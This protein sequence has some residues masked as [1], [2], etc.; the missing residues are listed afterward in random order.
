MR[1]V[2]QHGGNVGRPQDGISSTVAGNICSNGRGRHHSCGTGAGRVEREDVQRHLVG[3]LR[4]CTVEH[5]DLVREDI[6]TIHVD[7]LH[8]TRPKRRT[9]GRKQRDVAAVVHLIS[10]SRRDGQTDTQGRSRYDCQ[11]PVPH[12]PL[13][14]YRRRPPAA[15]RPSREVDTRRL[16]RT[17]R[18]EPVGHQEG[19]ATRRNHP[20]RTRLEQAPV[21]T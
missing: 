20:T 5:I 18:Q 15:A 9:T 7:V 4:L 19:H 1:G 11:N 13:L 10:K 8:E 17:D 21:K 12:W 6:G 3:R 14:L 2:A 16:R